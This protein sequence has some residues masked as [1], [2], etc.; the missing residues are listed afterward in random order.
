MLYLPRGKK[1]KRIIHPRP[2]FLLDYIRR[3]EQCQPAGKGSRN[4]RQAHGEGRSVN[5]EPYP[6]GHRRRLRP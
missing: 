1:K 4:S 2:E 3:A 6:G 5:A